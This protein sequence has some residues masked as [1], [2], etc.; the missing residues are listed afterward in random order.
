VPAL[1][2]DQVELHQLQCH[3]E[4]GEW[5]V[6]R[7]ETGE[8]VGLPAE[9]VTFLRELQ[10]SIS[11][12]AATSRVL[13]EH[14]EHIDGESFVVDLIDLGF[15]ARLGDE[16]I[17]DVPAPPS[18]PWLRAEHIRWVF[19]AWVSAGL[20]VFICACI[21]AGAIRGDLALTFHTY[22]LTRSPGID[23]AFNTLVFL[24]VVALHEFWHL[25]AA[26]ADGVHARIGLG[27]RLQF[28]A[29]QTTVTGL[30]GAPRR[31]RLRV[32]AAGM[33]SDLVIGSGC[34]IAIL[35]LPRGGLASRALEAV[36]L[37]IFLAIAQQFAFFMRTDVYLIVQELVR[38]K[39][40]YGDALS[41]ARYACRRIAVT[42]REESP[43]A[44]P[45]VNLPPHERVP[46]RI[47]SAFL[48]LGSLAAL[49]VFF[50]YGGP[51]LVELFVKAIHSIDAGIQGGNVA[52]IADGGVVLCVEGSLQVLLVT[53]LVRKHGPKMRAW[54][55]RSPSRAVAQ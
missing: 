1:I 55:S 53:M 22:F 43:P 33:I 2:A 42:F 52:D 20:L 40:L 11:I 10:A 17:D 7:A 41:Y 3:E 31:V 21:A 35:T 6:G 8:F 46:V 44:D 27:T 26:R 15:V 48:V 25:A 32:Y 30:W 24:I 39:N 37:G 23:L 51:I 50:L 47:Y 29:A 45:S 36:V 9:A 28:L 19:S 5:I 14:G 38:C 54:L 34:L 13:A 16:V 12:R 4:N 18:L 49:A